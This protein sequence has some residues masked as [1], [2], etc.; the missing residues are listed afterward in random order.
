[1]WEAGRPPSHTC[2]V[3]RTAPLFPAPN[4]SLDLA[5]RHWSS[6]RGEHIFPVWPVKDKDCIMWQEAQGQFQNHHH[7]TRDQT[8]GGGT[9]EHTFRPPAHTLAHTHSCTRTPAAAPGL[10]SRRTATRSADA[11]T[12]ARPSPAPPHTWT[13]LHTRARARPHPVRGSSQQAALP[14]CKRRWRL[15]EREAPGAGRLGWGRR[16]ARIRTERE[17]AWRIVVREVEIGGAAA[18]ELENWTCD[19]AE[20]RLRSKWSF[21]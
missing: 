21:F 16:G 12:H 1:M 20:L 8:R 7:P 19:R 3:W 6:R 9:L 5:T 10:R 14:H 2:G 4:S 18:A 17:H 13:L 11:G 15:V